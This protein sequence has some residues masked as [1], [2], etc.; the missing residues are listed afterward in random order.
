MPSTGTPGGRK[1][2]EARLRERFE[3]TVQENPSKILGVQVER[4]HKDRSIKLH[5]GDY[6]RGLLLKHDM[7]NCNPRD[8]PLEANILAQIRAQIVKGI[9]NQPQGREKEFQ[10]AQGELMWLHKTRA[11]IAFHIGLFARFTRSAGDLQMSWIKRMHRYLANDPEKGI[12]LAPGDELVL[13]GGS[14]A[15]WGGDEISQKSTGGHWLMLGKLGLVSYFSR[16]QRKVADSSAMAETYSA[17]ELVK[18]VIEIVGKLEE[19][20]IKVRRPIIL[21]QDNQSVIKMSKNPIAH[22]GSKHYRIPQAFIRNYVEEGLVKFIK[23]SSEDNGADMFT[24]QS[25]RMKFM[26]DVEAIMGRQ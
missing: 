16:L 1:L 14:D 26:H 8:T 3:I 6:V 10:K 17:H 2:A 5:Q 12:I 9:P 7:K 21:Q 15:D 11:N 18:K 4:N 23:V 20:G 22:S 24:K 13:H 19:M 25:G